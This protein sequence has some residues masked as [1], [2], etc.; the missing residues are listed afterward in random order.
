MAHA[1]SYQKILGIEFVSILAA[2]QFYK[3]KKPLKYY[4]QY[5]I[6][7]VTIIFALAEIESK[8]NITSNFWIIF[9]ID[10]STK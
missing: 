8:S 2:S 3:G 6:L 7:N 1:E 10:L 5:N 4:N 9:L